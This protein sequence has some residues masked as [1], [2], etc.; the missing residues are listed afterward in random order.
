VVSGGAHGQLQ[1]FTEPEA[2][3]AIPVSGSSLPSDVLM[4]L[5]ESRKLPPGAELVLSASG[6]S[7]L[8]GLDYQRYELRLDG[9]P[10][11]SEGVTLHLRDGVVVG[12]FGRISQRPLARTE[13]GLVESEAIASAEQALAWKLGVL[14]RALGGRGS[15]L[16]ELLAPAAVLRDG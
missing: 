4:E 11:I 1:P 2:V 5:A 7:A 13:P 10:V 6:A 3:E 8:A 16:G 12:A 15:D 9:V 14:A